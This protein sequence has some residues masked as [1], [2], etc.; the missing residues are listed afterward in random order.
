MKKPIQSAP[1]GKPKSLISVETR[2]ETHKLLFLATMERQFD[3]GKWVLASLLAVHAG[4]LLAI[5]QA[6]SAT[7]KLYQACGPLLI[8]GVAT[9]LV[10]GGLAWVNFSVAAVIYAG[11]LKDIREGR[12]PAL[13]GS[14]SI[15]ARL[16][17]LV[18]PIVAIA[19]LVLFLVAAV[20]AANV[21]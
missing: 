16:T 21:I 18:T 17:F 1:T 2:Y 7:A 13:T 10:A 19:S 15:V 12:E 4:S 3:Y 8:Y 6:G 11:F 20:R 9:T 5:S 14:K